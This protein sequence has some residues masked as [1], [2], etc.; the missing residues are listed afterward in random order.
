[1]SDTIQPFIED[2]NMEHC[3]SGA[4]VTLIAISAGSDAAESGALR[5]SYADQMTSL[6]CV[7]L[8]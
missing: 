5:S 8:G 6:S 7:Y 1:M 2:F 4:T 3:L